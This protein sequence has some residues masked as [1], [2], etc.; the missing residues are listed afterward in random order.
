[1]YNDYMRFIR[2][3]TLGFFSFVCI[4]AIAGCVYLATLQ[5][6]VLNRAEVKDWLTSGGVY[7]N[8]LVPSLLQANSPKTPSAA[9]LTN[10]QFTIAEDALATALQRTFTPEYVQT[11]AES[12]I[13]RFYDWVEGKTATLT[14]SI[15]V[16]QKKDMFITELTR[17]VEPAVAALPICT[18]TLV[19]ADSACRPAN[20]PPDM[21]VQTAI[22]ESVDKAAFFKQPLTQD[23]LTT[24]TSTPVPRSLLLLRALLPLAGWVVLMLVLI[25]I[26]S[27]SLVLWLSPAGKRLKA[28]GQ[29]GK[30]VFF[31]QLFTL[32]GSLFLIWA[33][34]SGLFRLSSLFSEQ[35]GQPAVLAE[36]IS[37]V[38][39]IA[40][41]DI[42]SRLALFSGIVC[43]VG[44][45]CW[46]GIRYLQGRRGPTLHSPGDSGTS[47][48]S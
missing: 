24:D 23:T 14:F 20:I 19:M 4:A 16:D 15:P 36:T 3:L 42:A 10:G 25:T 47:A 18:S 43:V 26:L 8:N 45:A 39:K 31:G 22:T 1:M 33:F 28:L 5:A 44:L 41:V 9:R 40:L 32:L 17:A 12:T 2:A 27:A 34:R 7:K 21:Y 35:S 30:R 6:T 38:V 29:L 37:N 48:L 46:V 13:D 11:Q